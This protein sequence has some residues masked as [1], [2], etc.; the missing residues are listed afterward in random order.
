MQCCCRSVVPTKHES[1][2]VLQL[3]LRHHRQSQSVGF[4][5]SCCRSPRAELLLEQEDPVL[6]QT[7]VEC[8]SGN[9]SF[10][11]TAD[12]LVTISDDSGHEVAGRN[13]SCA[14]SCHELAQPF[15]KSICII[16]AHRHIGFIIMGNVVDVVV[17]EEL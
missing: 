2:Y 11:V 3:L 15:G 5:G 13:S 1:C 17:C 7:Q 8:L 6:H 10:E 12:V 4:L 14:L 9:A 16:G